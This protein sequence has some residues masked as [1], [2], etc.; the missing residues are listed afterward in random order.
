MQRRVF[1]LLAKPPVISIL[2]GV[3]VTLGVLSIRHA[4]YLE[5]LELKAYDRVLRIQPS[6]K[7]RE[8]RTVL[9][10]I[11]EQDVQALGSWPLTDAVMTQ[12][13][14]TLLQYRP[15]V[16]GVDIYRNFP[17]P[18]GHDELE[19]VLRTH[20]NIITVTKFGGERL[21]SVPPPPVLKG[22]DQI[23]FNDILVDRDGIV[24]RGLLFLDDGQQFAYSFPLRLGLKYLQAE[25]VAPQPDPSNPEYLRLGTTTFRPLNA[26]DGGYVNA[27]ARG[28]QLLLDFGGTPA[29]LR[30]YSVSDILDGRVDLGVLTDKIVL[31][32]VTAESVPDFFHTPYS[33]GLGA[34]RRSMYGVMV[35]AYTVNQLIR[36]ALHGV[37]PRAT[38]SETQEIFWTFLWG[39]LGSYIGTASRCVWRFSI[40]A[41]A[42]LLSLV[43]L[44]ALSFL[45]GWWLPVVPPALACVISA[46][47][48]AAAMASQEKRDR[49]LLMHLF[50]RHV[51]PE[52]ADT[53]WQQRDLFWDGGRPRSEA[54][55]ITVLFSDLEGFTSASE[56]MD[57]ALLMDW[58]NTYV[59]TMAK[60]VMKH[61]GVVDDYFGDAIKANFG[62]P[63]ARTSESEIAEDARNAV[64]CA[65]AMEAEMGRLNG[66]WSDRNLPLAR[67]RIGIFTGRAVAGSLGSA[68][69][70]KY[71]TI[72]D[73]VNIAARLEGFNKDSWEPGPGESPCRILLGEST[74][75][76]L[77]PCYEIRRVGEVA[78]KGKDE[79]VAVY[80]LMGRSGRT[81]P[82][83]ETVTPGG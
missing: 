4:G 59:E 76:H 22:T 52:V 42:S 44:F 36:S 17:V 11:T 78:L 12:L 65:L 34:D 39:L 31:I 33:S 54:V 24:R 30:S 1:T 16:I 80:Q 57:P 50:S 14:E 62:V 61:G 25:G 23:G 67:M 43:A 72:G 10:G 19:T 26:D 13:L 79:K 2:V 32:G 49:A 56:K 74:V 68:E 8:L 60:L 58:M 75:H 9:V 73:T 18:P 20:P 69:R 15:R 46:S 48:V 82:S 45:Q 21:T 29:P 55:T 70:L 81:A 35:H 3:L 40:L 47:L 53:I 6:E 37:S 77:D 71:T 28:Y 83:S 27:D 41:L 63:L 66:Q 7:D 51:S 5:P 64:E 38:L